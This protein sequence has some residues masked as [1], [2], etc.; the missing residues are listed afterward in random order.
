MKPYKELGKISIVSVISH[1]SL[2]VALR[3]YLH[4]YSID[5]VKEA[6]LN[7]L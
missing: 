2:Y 5:K 7:V 6:I 1:L 3:K 4:I